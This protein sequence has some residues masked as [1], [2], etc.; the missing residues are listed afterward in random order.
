[1]KRC[2]QCRLDYFDDSLL[3]C[4]ADGTP[5]V[6]GVPGA[7]FTGEA[8]TLRLSNLDIGNYGSPSQVPISDPNAATISLSG[9]VPNSVA[10]LPF[11]HLSSDPDDEYFCDGLAEELI[12]ALSRIEDLKVVART[13]AFSFKGKNLD[14]SQVGT[15]LNVSN[16]VEGSVRKSGDRMRISVQLINA[17]DG[18]NIWSE[19]Y[20]TEIRDIFD[21]QDEITSSVVNALKNKLLKKPTEPDATMASLLNELKHHVHAVEAY[22]LYLRGR[23]LFSK[24]N[25]PDLYRALE[26]FEQAIA[27]EP[28]FAEAYSGIADVHMWLTELGPIAPLEGMPKAKEAARK[29]L[30]LNP[31]LSEAHTSL[32]IVLQEFDYDFA[33]AEREY[34]KAIALNANN[35]LAHQMYGALLAQLGRFDE[36]NRSFE[37]S[38]AL[39]PLSPMGSWI[40]PFGLF[41]E[42][43]F[44]DSIERATKILEL[45]GGFAAAYLILSFDYQMKGDLDAGKENYCRFLEIFGLTTIAAEARAGYE[46][47]GWEGFLRAMTEPHVR[48][49]VTAYISAVFFTALGDKEAAIRCLE[50]SYEKREGHIVMLNVDPRFDELRSDPRFQR[51]IKTVGFPA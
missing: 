50:E 1:M 7:S 41:L 13:S 21:V 9:Y 18:Y 12:N 30:E 15:I 8:T 6:Q 16:V 28:D 17:S 42:R 45:D 32:G 27:V 5:L 25:E 11:A 19:K 51:I 48:T 43:R 39:D 33:E 37:R 31:D 35:A 44:D 49:A 38:L 3:Y 29:A 36:A 34:A 26:C 14:V 4:L 46:A 24:F 23:F 47:A 10:V 2:P 22:Q 20:D 40:Y